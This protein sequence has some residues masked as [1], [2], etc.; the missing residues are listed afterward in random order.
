M[1]NRSKS[2]QDALA[3][4]A[5]EKHYEQ[6]AEEMYTP[7]EERRESETAKGLAETHNQVNE[8]Y[9]AGSTEDPYLLAGPD[10]AEDKRQRKDKQ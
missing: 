9:S 2:N 6:V 7:G 5:L 10:Q 1:E 3:D 8:D 4:Q